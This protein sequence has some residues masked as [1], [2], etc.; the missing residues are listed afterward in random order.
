MT[1]SASDFI[2]VLKKNDIN[3]NSTQLMILTESLD[4]NTTGSFDLDKVF[5][6][7]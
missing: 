2:N 1:I 6:F 5:S 7:C 4:P 3:L